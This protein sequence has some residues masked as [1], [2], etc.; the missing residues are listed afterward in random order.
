[1][2]HVRIGSLSISRFVLGGNPISGFSHL[3][4]ELDSRMRHYFTSAQVK[5]LLREAEALG[6]N[7][8]MA[9]TDHHIARLLMEY[10]DEGGAVQWIAQTAPELGSITAGIRNAIKGGAKAC[11]VHGGVADHL[12]ASG[13]MSEV[14]DALKMIRDAGMP[15]GIA[16]HLPDTLRWAEAEADLDFYMCCYYNPIPRAERA[17]NPGAGD[18]LF[19]EA[20]RET[21]V[22][23]IATLSRPAIHYKI[24]A[25]GRTGPK[26][27]FGFAARHLRTGDAVCV[28]IYD[29]GKPGM[30]REDVELFESSRAASD[31]TS[32]PST[33]TTAE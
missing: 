2:Q 13:D 5:R 4:P 10:W 29:E 3:T 20:D 1:M 22:R 14:A 33:V 15:A 9:R 17:E 12:Y 19:L 7:T 31:P 28:G 25:A 8:I 21:M 32:A 11:Y 6:V 24:L 16:G 26:E 27:A 23:T 30:L 18:E